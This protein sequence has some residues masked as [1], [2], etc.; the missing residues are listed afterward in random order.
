M[1]AEHAAAAVDDLPRAL[2]DPGVA[3]E[4]GGTAR[5][6]EE[7][8]ILRVG[9][10]GDRELRL[11]R[12]LAHLRL[13]QLAEREAHPRERVGR[14][15]GEHVGLV[16]PGV[17]RGAQ[18]RRL[19]VRSRLDPRVVAGRQRRGAEAVGEVEHRVEPH[20]AVAA[21]ARVR[22]RGRR[23]GRRETA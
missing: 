6:G 13:G 12:Q 16:L 5:A 3:G 1:T 23:D 7:A 21:D 9:L 22:R 11:R 14:Q 19:A 4:E 8:E 20:V 17:D 2:L 10:G 15:R 18:Q